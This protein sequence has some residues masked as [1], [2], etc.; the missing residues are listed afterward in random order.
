MEQF[1]F[2]FTHLGIPLLIAL[3]IMFHTPRSRSGLV[4]STM[5][6]LAILGFLY[7]WGQ[8]PIAF[9]LYFKY[10]L[11]FIMGVS[12]FK[13]FRSL[14]FARKSFPKGVFKNSGNGLLVVLAMFFGGLIF[15]LVKGRS[16]EEDTVSL[17]FPLKNGSYYIGS[18]GSN[19]VINNHFGTKAKSQQYAIDINKIGR[20]GKVSKG[21]KDKSNDAHYI[22]G[23]KIY[24]PC[25]GK[26]L[27][28]VNTVADNES[29]S[30]NVSAEDGQGNF[31]TLDCKGF[32]V[33][34]VHLR[35]GSIKVALGQFISTGDLIGQVGNSGF[36]QEPHL[37]LQAA[38]L[39][40]DSVLVGVPMEF[41]D[42][43]P[44][45]N[46]LFKN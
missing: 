7:L 23:E 20:I 2:V 8:W 1:L 16:Y 17:Q 43:S 21:F 41:M 12:L 44:V 19:S 27:E 3:S 42:Q 11:L 14:L 46:D 6:H 15:Y 39:N 38:K 35:K 26:V 18:G 31:V 10:V 32:I 40:Q 25:D 24:S 30:M 36:S 28:M 9:S 33:S 29:T 34:M 22:F 4:T 37:H 5:F 13:L 45:R